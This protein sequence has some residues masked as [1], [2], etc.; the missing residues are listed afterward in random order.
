MQ[1]HTSSKSPRITSPNPTPISK[2][3]FSENR[4]NSISSPLS[5]VNYSSTPTRTIYENNSNSSPLRPDN[6]PSANYHLTQYPPINSPSTHY[7]PTPIRRV[8][9]N[10]SNHEYSDA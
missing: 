5:P 7:P 6:Y 4:R 8:Y 9:E 10:N 2:S 1:E 3:P